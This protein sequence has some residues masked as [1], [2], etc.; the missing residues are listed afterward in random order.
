M[1]QSEIFSRAQKNFPKDE[2]ANNAR[3]LIRAGFIN[4]EMAGVYSLLPLGLRVIKNIEQ[5]IREEMEAMGGREMLMSV[6]HPK[7]NWDKTGRWGSFDAL[8]RVK[9]RDGKEFALGPTHEEIVVPLMKKFIE[10]YKDLPVYVYQIQNKLRDEPR[11]KSGLL[12][13]R[14]FLMKDFYSFHSSED[15]LDEFYKKMMEAYSRLFGK[16]G[17]STMIVEAS[18]GTFC[19]YSHEFQ[20]LSDVGEDT[21]FYCDRIDSGKPCLFA[22]NKELADKKGGSPCPKCDHPIK[23]AS[24]IEV[25]NIFKLGTNFSLPFDLSYKDKSGKERNVFM[26]CYGIGITRVMGAIVETLSD[27]DGLVWPESVSPFK[28]HLLELEGASAENI[29]QVLLKR[30]VEVLYDDRR[31]SAG[32]KFAEA[33]MVGIPYRVVISP[34]T[35]DKVELK[36]RAGKDVRLIDFNELVAILTKTR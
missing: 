13:G 25:G 30:G 23:V 21:I 36:E 31:I 2:E 8:Y 14:E 29:Y 17:L 16:I 4:K 18:G 15:D 19:K 27:K 35:G 3:L 20:V 26:G 10:S 7:E 6:M 11:A 12:R 9:A 24:G 1:K 5:I 22:Q 34:K 32:E 28:V 33:D